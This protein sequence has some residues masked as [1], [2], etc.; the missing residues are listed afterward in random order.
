V[1]N[2]RAQHHLLVEEAGLVR[3]PFLVKGRLV[4]P[5]EMGR[6]AIV[7]AFAGAEAGAGYA[8][9][10]NCQ[11]IRQPV[12]DRRSMRATGDYLY[13]V[14]P[15]ARPLD[16]IDTEFDQLVSGPYALTVEA[17]LDYLQAIAGMLQDNQATVDGARDLFRRT[18]EHPDVYL[19][20]AFAALHLGL[21]ARAARAMVDAE[22]A[23]WMIPGSRFLDGWVD[24][25]AEVFPGLAP[26][27]AQ[28]L[29]AGDP[30]PPDPLSRGGR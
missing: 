7:A 1:E 26:L 12:I 18:S 14:L 17:V 10:P 24:V 15:P 5:P 19:D 22:L 28:S 25:P 27:L 2:L 6:D 11:L 9:L 16:L 30:G 13:Q 4:L 8:K 20:A 3:V 21:D 29:P 23:H